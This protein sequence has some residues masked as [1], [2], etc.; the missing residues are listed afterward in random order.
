MSLLLTSTII[1]PCFFSPGVPD[2]AAAGALVP[3]AGQ[4]GRRGGP[5]RRTQDLDLRGGVPPPPP[6]MDDQIQGELIIYCKSTCIISS[7]GSD[8]TCNATVQ[9]CN[10]VCNPRLLLA[11]QERIQNQVR[12]QE[13]LIKHIANIDARF[14]PHEIMKNHTPDL[15][16]VQKVTTICVQQQLYEHNISVDQP[17]N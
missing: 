16:Q 2:V 12:L 6:G 5:L 14:K 11:E 7:P 4:A 8:T 3:A 1:A 13:S 15:P 10:G 17:F 9:P